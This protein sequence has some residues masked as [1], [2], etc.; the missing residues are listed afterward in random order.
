MRAATL[1]RAR[2]V[3]FGVK[4][5]DERKKINTRGQDLQVEKNGIEDLSFRFEI[6]NLKSQ[7]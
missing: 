7:V 5:C 3:D 4:L 6:S 2:G 1:S